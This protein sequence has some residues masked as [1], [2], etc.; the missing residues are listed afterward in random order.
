MEMPKPQKEHEKLRALAGSW[1]GEEKM[2]P[3][4]WDP[5]GGPAAATIDSRMDLDGFHLISDYVQKRG[6]QVTY[7]GHGVFGYNA[8]RKCYEMWWFDSMGMTPDG[9]ASGKW[10][11]DTLMFEHQTPMG[12]SRYTYTLKGEGRYAF[13]IQNS[14]DGKQWASFMDGTYTKK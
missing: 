8:A 3:S 9:A 2:H 4:P 12:F 11:G 5:Q 1:I 6:G 14:Q 10:E 7:R 13:G